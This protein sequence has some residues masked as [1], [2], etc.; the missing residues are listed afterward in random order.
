MNVVYNNLIPF[1]GFCVI[2]LFGVV[3][4][5]RECRPLPASTINHE[6]IHTA[7]MRELLYAGFY[8]A[9]GIEWLCRLLR[10]WIS[11]ASAYRTISFEREAYGCRHIPDYAGFRQRFAKWRQREICPHD[12][13][14]IPCRFV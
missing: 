10:Q 14:D 2:N 7:Q 3:F 9:Y 4:A 11:G 1:W 6:A 5:R 8:L 13:A 12:A